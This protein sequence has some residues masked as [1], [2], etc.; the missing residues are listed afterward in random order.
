M[1]VGCDAGFLN[2]AKIK[3][4][5]TAMKSG[6]LA[7]EAIFEQLYRDGTAGKK[8]FDYTDKV[9]QSWL[10]Q[11]LYQARNFSSAF[12]KF[13]TLLGGVYHVVTQNIF[14]DALPIHL[15]HKKPD[16]AS[17]DLCSESKLV[18]YPKPD[19]Q[20]SFDK[21][22]SVYLSNTNHQ[23]NQPVHLQ[24]KDTALPLAINLPK[25]AEPA[26]RYC[27]AGVYEI[28][29]QNGQ[30]LFQINFSKSCQ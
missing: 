10:H 20:I 27:P 23:D 5:H 16:Y 15:H 29:E 9:T 12:H 4:S 18:V 26:Q 6:M 7:A 14:R 11:E 22:S 3:G 25:Y 21:P 30:S 19:Q 8:L 1:L 2:G 28:V 24:L 13:G 17:L